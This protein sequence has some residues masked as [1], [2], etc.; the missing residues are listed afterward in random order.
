MSVTNIITE[1]GTHYQ[2]KQGMIVGGEIDEP[3]KFH[4]FLTGGG[5]EFELGAVAVGWRMV[6]IFPNRSTFI[7]SPIEMHLQARRR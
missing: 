3:C 1:S 7:T 2:V 4:C 6:G 5:V